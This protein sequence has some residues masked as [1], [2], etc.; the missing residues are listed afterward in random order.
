MNRF[1]KI[2]FILIL[3]TA[4]SNKAFSQVYNIDHYMRQDN[5]FNNS[6]L[7]NYGYTL[8]MFLNSFE[9]SR[10]N[11]LPGVKLGII[12]KRTYVKI[13]KDNRTGIM[14]GKKSLYC[15][16]QGIALAFNSRINLNLMVHQGE[17]GGTDRRPLMWQSNLKYNLVGL[18]SMN[19]IYVGVGYGEVRYVKDYFYKQFTI[20]GMY[21][22]RSR[23]AGYT[24]GVGVNRYVFDIHP[25]ENIDDS[26]Y[27]KQIIANL[28]KMNLG[29]QFNFQEHWQFAFSYTRAYFNSYQ[30]ELLFYF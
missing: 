15:D 21:N 27:S 1:K 24:V 14:D 6:M 20:E 7:K 11:L 28:F 16:M 3:F 30:W 8:S 13:D 23:R 4:M 9:S 2:I 26:Y 19:H 18:Q 12:A 17:D 25:S 29:L 10:G 22:G 5:S